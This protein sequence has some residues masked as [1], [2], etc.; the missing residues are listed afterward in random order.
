[1][2]VKILAVD[3]ERDMLVLLSRIL[4]VEQGYELT[5][6]DDPLK[7][8]DILKSTDFD[9]LITDLKMPHCSG[10]QLLEICKQRSPT[11]A[12]IIITAHG[13]IDSA[14]EATRKGAF[15]YLT[16]PFRRERLLHVIE[17]AQRWRG[18]ELENRVLREKLETEGESPILIGRSP[19]MDALQGQINKVAGTLATILITG[20]SGTGKELVA[21]SI[22]VRSKRAGRP[23]VP[24]NC[25]AIP[26]SLMESELFG[27]VR[28]AFTGAVKDKKGLVEEARGGTLFLDE[29]ADIS[30][31]MQAKLLRLLQE[32]EFKCVGDSR[33]RSAD[34]RFIAATHQ[35]L[36]E[37]IR[38]GL[39]REDLYYRLNVINIQLP[40]LRE[41]IED[42]PLL[43]K[44]FFQKYIVLHDKRGLREIRPE[45]MEAL[46]AAQWPGNVR[47]LENV[48]ERGVILA[49]GSVLEKADLAMD[50]H[51]SSGTGALV[52]DE[53]FFA[54]PFKA[55]KD[56]LMEE[57]Q[58][59]YLSRVLTRHG[60]NVSQAARDSGLKRQYLHKLMRNAHVTS[61]RFK[62]AGEAPV[63]GAKP[64][65]NR[66]DDG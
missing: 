14:I 32:G 1:M 16:K 56:R 29:I 55:A 63:A 50:D 3:D 8:Q 13:T 7:A 9:I 39:F 62:N 31:A 18:M 60:G 57:F 45:A 23:F 11:A 64:A 33:G 22:H 19:A 2:R 51:D 40:P 4:T 27:H 42:I 52:A 46:V 43:V 12:V 15:D 24:V 47:E 6:T 53:D 61:Q 66:R 17:Q 38:D 65:V 36:H 44:F 35:D 26:E 58:S 49:T 48:V 10:M 41:R 21:R 59:A 54:L 5:V 34:A 28:G 25:G 20:E 30:P 37:R